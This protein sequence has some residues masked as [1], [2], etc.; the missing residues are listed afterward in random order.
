M[1][2]RFDDW[3]NAMKLGEYVHKKGPEEKRNQ[4]VMGILSVIGAVTVIAAIAYAVYKYLNPGCMDDFDDDFDDYEEDIDDEEYS[5]R[6]TSDSSTGSTGN[7]ASA[8]N[9]ASANNKASAPYTESV[10]DD[11]S[12]SD[13][14]T[15]D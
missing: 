11:D 10:S 7:T 8:S 5:F 4:I 3:L 9:T 14:E 13:D 15:N 6:S 12:V 1:G 2:N